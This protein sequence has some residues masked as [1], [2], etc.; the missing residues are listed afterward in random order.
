MNK[1]EFWIKLKYIG[2]LFEK[3]DGAINY[4]LI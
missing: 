3:L 4:V 1:I 2:K